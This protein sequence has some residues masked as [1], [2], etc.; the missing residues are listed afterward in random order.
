M[1]YK[2]KSDCKQQCNAFIGFIMD[3]IIKL[4]NFYFLYSQDHVL[5]W[6][7]GQ[8]NIF[9]NSVDLPRLMTYK[10]AYKIYDF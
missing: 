6:L 10:N 3:F 9:S 1:V 2:A 5:I 7:D 4:I 8:L